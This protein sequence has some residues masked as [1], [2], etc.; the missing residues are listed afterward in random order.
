MNKL[1]T[2]GW[3]RRTD[4]KKIE[5]RLEA[6]TK[7]CEDLCRICPNGHLPLTAISLIRP[8]LFLTLCDTFPI[9]VLKTICPKWPL[10][11]PRVTNLTVVGKK[12]ETL[13]VINLQAQEKYGY[14]GVVW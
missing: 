13:R 4:Q 6:D 11:V 8:S 12:P 3:L 10:L 7:K 1:C 2:Q 14:F 5:L 9:I